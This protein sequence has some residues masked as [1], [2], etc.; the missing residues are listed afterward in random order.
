MEL[1]DALGLNL[2]IL[3]AQFVNFAI[4]VFVLY[5][6]GY[7]PIIEF[8]DKRKEK[9]EQG[10]ENAEE[11]EKRLRKADHDQE[12]ILKDAKKEAQGIILMAEEIAKKSKEEII[13]KSQEEAQR[14]LSDS[15]KKIKEEREKIFREIKADVA[16]LVVSA[17]EVMLGEKIDKEK[18]KQIIEKAINKNSNES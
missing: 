4:L 18:N 10:I 2:K 13:N 8:L 9:V 3:I 12:K 16:D 17:S 14:I 11:A 7:K 1:F 5:R 6:F 15:Q